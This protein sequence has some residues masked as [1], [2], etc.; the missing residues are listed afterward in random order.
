MLNTYYAIRHGQS[1]A[2]VANLISSCPVHGATH[3]PLTPLGRTQAAAAGERLREELGADLGSLTL[4]SSAF[5]RAVETRDVAAAALRPAFSQARPG[6]ELPVG[7]LGALRERDFGALDGLPTGVYDAVWP[8]DREDAYARHAD[9]VEP[10]ASVVGRLA[11]MLEALERRHAGE[12]LGL[13]AHADVLQ[14]FQ[15]WLAGCDVRSFAEYRFGNGE[16][17]ECGLDAGCL[18]FPEPMKSQKHAA[19]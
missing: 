8:R 12:A 15:C 7:V 2:N 18:P 6:S 14:I 1:T 4:Y 5:L 19:A 17:R 16:V 11:E 3:H 13:V 9:G 10:V